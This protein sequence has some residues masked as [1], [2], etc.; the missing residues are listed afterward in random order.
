MKK[1]ILFLLT[2]IPM[3]AFSPTNPFNTIESYKEKE[4]TAKLTLK[5]EKV[6]LIMLTLSHVES[7]GNYYAV[8]GSGDAGKY[9]ILSDTWKG[10]CILYFKKQLDTSPENQD[11]LVRVVISDWLEKGL[12]IEQIAAKWN[13]GTHT[14]WANKKGINKFGIPFDVPKYVYTFVHRYNKI[15]ETYLL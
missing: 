7:G 8:G 11:L 13:C 12:T 4:E 6:T 2:L 5:Y 1:I 10:W 9:Q 14:G 3:Y 15:K